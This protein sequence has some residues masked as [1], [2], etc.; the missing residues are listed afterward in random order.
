MRIPPRQGDSLMAS[1]M[2]RCTRL[3]PEQMITSF[4]ADPG[5]RVKIPVP[6]PVEAPSLKK[7][8]CW[9]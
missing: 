5:N 9:G 4:Y 7:V 1:S 3:C 2:A 8:T 6:R